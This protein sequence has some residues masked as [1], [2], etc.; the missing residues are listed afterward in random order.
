M[1][2]VP[3]GSILLSV[4]NSVVEVVKRYDDICGEPNGAC[5]VTLEIP[6]DMEA[7]IYF[8]YQL[9]N[10]FQNHR[11]YVK[12]R[13]DAQLSGQGDLSISDYNDCSPMANSLVEPSKRLYPCGL[14]ANSFFTGS[15]L[16]L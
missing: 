9:T 12:S 2:F 3:L 11:R 13:S 1:L 10:F 15:K 14:I 8:Y 16:I 7:P 5:M 6:R 4:S